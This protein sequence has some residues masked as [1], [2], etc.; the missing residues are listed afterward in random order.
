[1]QAIA[2]DALTAIRP[3][4]VGLF[5]QEGIA[6]RRWIVMSHG[7][8]R[9]IP[10]EAVPMDNNVADDATA[11]VAG[12]KN[13]PGLSKEIGY[14]PNLAALVDLRSGFPVPKTTKPIAVIADP[15]LPGDPRYD[16]PIAARLASI[17][18]WFRQK[19]LSFSAGGW[20]GGGTQL[21]PVPETAQLGYEVVRLL[22]GSTDSFYSGARARRSQIEATGDLG[23]ARVLLFATHGE[24][25]ESFPQ[26]GEPFLALT[27]E[28]S[29]PIGFDP[30]IASEISR[31]SM[32]PELVLLSACNT[33][34]PDGTPAQTGLS[35]LASLFLSAGARALVITGW[36][37]H[38]RTAYLAI[39]EALRVATENNAASGEALRRARL[40]VAGQF[41]HPFYWSAFV[42]IGDPRHK[43]E[44]R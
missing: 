44:F 13:W 17:G 24:T 28:G 38:T 35:G 2:I 14:L 20:L 4:T 32:D 25:S 40:A 43:W 34:A 18:D 21:A 5:E 42:Y 29:N 7:L 3:F 36:K 12:A 9:N 15:V 41:A 19:R 39:T 11:V 8:L 26:I 23:K 22:Q 37:V 16:S 27:S 10:I 30:L 1:L 6:K 31:L 33:A